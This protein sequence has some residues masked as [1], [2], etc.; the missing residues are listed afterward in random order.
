MS[1][2]TQ[3]QFSVSDDATRIIERQTSEPIEIGW[4]GKLPAAG[5]FLSRRLPDAF[6]L[7]WDTWLCAGMLDAK[8][9]VAD[10]WPELFLSFPV[11]R[12][13]ARFDP[14][15]QPLWVGLLLPGVD[16]VGRLFPLTVALPVSAE[17][18]LHRSIGA[19]DQ[20]L[21]RIQALALAVL[22][23]DNIDAFDSALRTLP[24]W[25]QQSIIRNNATPPAAQIGVTHDG[26]DA[27]QWLATIGLRQWLSI[28]ES[29]LFWRTE[30]GDRSAL[31]VSP[32]PPRAEDFTAMVLARL[33]D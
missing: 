26:M 8:A 1:E 32:W 4:Y 21:D 27:C 2:P 20:H 24:A 19:L 23:D 16:R 7:P 10:D 5:D 22:E 15:N 31:R 28:A 12:F 18:L 14:G 25:R 13:V 6:R 29:T 30:Q 33:S 17:T 3:E 9:K 11:W